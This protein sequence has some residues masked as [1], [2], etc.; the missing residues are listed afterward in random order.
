MQAS[1]R[2]RGLRDGIALREVSPGVYV[3]RYTLKRTDRVA[4][5]A[6]VRA[7]VRH[8]NRTVAANY[9]LSETMGAPVAVA[10]AAPVRPPEPALRI[11]RFGMAPVERI[12]PGAEL[13]FMV[14]AMP[15]ATVTVDL[16]GVERDL[17]L[18]ETQPGHYEGGYTIRRADNINPNRPVVA[19]LRAGERVVTASL[20]IAGT[21]P[22]ADNRPPAGD[23]RP[24]RLVNLTPRDGE[25]VL[26]GPPILVSGNFED[27]VSGVDP[28]SVRI[29]VSGRN[30]TP[31]AQI[32]ARSFSYRSNLPAG[33]HTVEVTARDN[34]GNV[35]R[36]GWS[37]DVGVA[38]R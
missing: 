15:G 10:P 4:G 20:N 25:T 18:R 32:D 9:V 38:V 23:N 7:V 21:R 22:G 34:A 16:P 5:D 36:Q 2:I 12:E 26:A 24:P 11:E 33:R 1:V 14:D 29:V 17:R 3:G 31:E 37:F 13:R 27:R 28:A 30:V 6:A 19:T 8:G 35:L